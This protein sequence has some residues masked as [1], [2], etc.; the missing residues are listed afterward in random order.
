MSATI[1]NNIS[2]YFLYFVSLISA[3]FVIFIGFVK[4]GFTFNL[5]EEV[6]GDSLL[7]PI[8]NFVIVSFTPLVIIILMMRYFNFKKKKELFLVLIL[9]IIVV[10]SGIRGPILSP[11]FLSLIIYFIYKKKNVNLL[12][13]FFISFIFLLIAIYL[14]NLREGNL[15]FINYVKSIPYKIF[16]GNNFSDLRD[17]AWILAYWDGVFI[18][19]KSYLAALLSFIPRDL[20]PFR[21]EW[22]ISIYTNRLVGFDSSLHAGLRPGPFGESYLNFGFL[23]V[24]IVGIIVGFNLRYVDYKMKYILCEK[25]VDI[26][27]FYSVTINYLLLQN[28]MI[29]ASFW[30][31]Y[32]YIFV[33]FIG[34]LI[35]EIIYKKY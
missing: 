21:E 13:L 18:H 7:R 6:L 17:F 23:G 8:F 3:S 29:T 35:R 22:A 19:G 20:V 2:T 26:I 28:L 5:R 16:F 9:I 24:I 25:K 10:F 15:S 27:S 12:K 4:Y 14:G 33:I 30:K 11:L 32:I 34:F 31:I 1:K